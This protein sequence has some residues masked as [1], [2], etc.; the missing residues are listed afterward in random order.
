MTRN[1]TAHSE[2]PPTFRWAEAHRRHISNSQLRRMVADGDIERIARGLYRRTDVGISDDD[3]IEIAAKRPEATLCLTS[4]LARHGLTD[5]IPSLIDIAIPRNTW[6]PIVRPPV[7]W[8]EFDRR[9]FTIGRSMVRLDAA[10][11]IG[12]YSP[13]RSIIDAYRLRHTQGSDQANAALRRWLRAGGQPS[14]ILQL[15]RE[16]PRTAPAIRSVLEVLL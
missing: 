13:E 2:L 4:A 6:H 5:D 11:E 9:T 10:T 15:A 14:E 12:L 16:F 8:H 7:R 1:P 3:L